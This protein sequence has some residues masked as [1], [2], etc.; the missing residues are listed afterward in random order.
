[1]SSTL[2]ALTAIDSDGDLI[3]DNQEGYN[4][5]DEDGI[6][7]YLDAIAECNVMPQQ[8][9]T[10]DS[11]LVEGDAGVCIRKGNTLA[12]GETGG[13]QLTSDELNSA[14]NDADDF[15]NVGGI[16]DYIA[17]GLPVDGQSYRI[18][19]PQIV[20]IPSNAVYRKYN[21]A[22][23]W[24]A[25][26][27]DADNQIH[28]SAG[29]EGFCPPPASELWVEGLNAGDWCVQ[30]TIVDGGSNDDD[31]IANGTI[32]DPGGVAV[33][34]SSNTTPVAVADSA[35]VQ[36]DSSIIIN[37][38]DNDTDADGDILSIGVATAVLGTVTVTSDNQLEYV[39]ATDLLVSIR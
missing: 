9:A 17:S 6:P 1:M 14:T 15:G 12:A 10:Q 29:Q 37:V 32:V 4:D 3:P 24:N 28:S 22:S 5:N 30:L 2:A 27:E 11:F 21:N 13:L 36:S 26:V 25:F 16:F 35:R 33:V 19:F 20:P 38:L 34:N 7:D 18:V 31:G 23:G 8:A 39:P